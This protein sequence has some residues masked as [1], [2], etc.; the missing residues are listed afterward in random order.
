MQ[1]TAFV[2]LG[3]VWSTCQKFCVLILMGDWEHEAQ[4]GKEWRCDSLNQD[5][6]AQPSRA[7]CLLCR[8]MDPLSVTASVIAV[9][10]LTGVAIGYFHGV[11]SAPKEC[12]RCTLEASNLQSFPTNLR[13]HLKDATSNNPGKRL[14][15]HS[16]FRM[17]RSTSTSKDL[18]SCFQRSQ[19]RMV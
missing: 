2:V 16:V 10:Q 19:S 8:T 17:D 15:G 7:P 13:F 3:H 6:V 9:L 12:R 11:K 5:S 4:Q 1:T 14:S 18:S